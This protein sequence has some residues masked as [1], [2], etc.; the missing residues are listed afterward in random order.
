MATIAELFDRAV[1]CHR[2]GN[3]QQAES[4]YR[5]VLGAEPGHAA[6][7]HLLGFLAHQTGQ[8]DLAVKLIRQA[9]ALNPTEADYHFSLGIVFMSQ[10]QAA[11]AIACY[12]QTLQINPDHA[13]A[14]N[15]LGNAFKS[16]GQFAQAAECYRQ[17]LR[18][19]PHL[20]G[21]HNNLG[22]AL[23]ELGQP[24][25]AIECYR[26][27]LQHNPHDADALSNLVVVFREQGRLQEAEHC[28]RRALELYPAHANALNSL[29]MVL[30]DLGQSAAAAAS[31]Q[32]ALRIA[33]DRAH[34]HNNLGSVFMSQRRWA[35]ATICFQEA[36][37]LDP[38][39]ANAHVN[40]GTA[41]RDQ[42][43]LAEA[44]RCYREAMRINPQLMDAH[45]NLGNVFLDQGRRQQAAACYAQALRL[46][47]D[48]AATRYNQS[49]LRLL[50][51]DLPEAW[52]DYEC[53]W[54]KP[55]S[56]QRH[57]D[58]PRW[59]GAPLEG[60]TILLHAEQG[61]GDTIQFVRYVPLVKERGGTVLFECQPAL[62]RLLS[63]IAGV[64]Q[65]V[66]AGAAL[67]ECDVQAPLLSLPGIFG[68]T[69]STIPA[70]VPYLKANGDLVAYWRKELAV[71]SGFKVGI[72]WQ[73]NPCHTADRN[74]SI[75]L[76][77]FEA[78]ARVPG[79]QLVSVQKG[80][81][82]D[83]VA[84][85]QGR[86]PILDL[87][88]RLDAAGAFLDTAAIMMNLDL[89]ITVDSA[90]A[91]LAGALGVPVWVALGIGPD[92][93]WLLERSDSPWYPTMRLFRQTRYSDWS[94]VF[95]DMAAALRANLAERRLTFGAGAEHGNH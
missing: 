72:A 43:Q 23:R 1:A 91:H 53:R 18:I 25:K 49:Q 32:Q 7:Y 60:K 10:D 89:V 69:L 57:I 56:V 78:L 83:Q 20:A 16:Q 40:L 94:D 85:V 79:I 92:W 29:G 17:A 86:V 6:A 21:A 80:P 13:A 42:G 27:A 30:G 51:G 87:G 15:N 34:V 62:Q 73:G 54:K 58:R 45:N 35:E 76:A 9:I 68:T 44:E 4:F 74:R 67:P 41:F 11:Q 64:D 90:V 88:Q 26:Q 24:A 14:Y 75:A 46:Q 2:S 63:G 95:E 12:R 36:L 55:G 22:V 33:P 93:R 65:L 61:L 50:Q 37:R 3:L 38:N 8:H 66:A 28:A 19:E 48:H 5:Q 82:S 47:P 31:Y 81:G 59:N 71:L 39:Y 52:A 77:H 70:T 84:A